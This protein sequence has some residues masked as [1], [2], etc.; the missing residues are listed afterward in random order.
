[1]PMP[2]SPLAR[3]GAFRSELH[4]SFTR[5]ADALFELGD[6]LLCSQPPVPSLPHLSLEPTHRR[7]WGSAYAA[8]ASGRIATERLRD[9]LVSQLPPAD[10]LVFAVDVTTW[11]RCDAE[12][13]PER[14]YYYHPSR[15]SAGQPIIAGWAYQWIAQ[16]SFDRD[17]WTAP[18]DA[19]RL[20]PLDDTDQQA[21]VQVRALLARLPAGGP[22]PWFVFD[23]GYD[24]AQ[25]TLDLAEAPV[26]VLVRL[27]SNRCFYADP[28]PRGPGSTGRP[29]RHGAKFN[30]A[31]PTT[32]SAPTTTHVVVDDQYGAVTVKAWTGLH[33]KQQRHLG[34][35]SRGPRPIVRGTIIRVQVDRVPARTRPPKVL[36]LWWS[37]PASSTWIWPGGP[38]SAG[39]TWSTPSGSPSR[40]SAGRPHGPA[41]PSRP[42]AGPGWCWPH[43]P[44]Y[45]WPARP[46]AISGCRGSGPDPNRDSRPIGC[47]AAF[48]S[49][50]LRSARRRP[51]R[52]PP[53]AP[54]AG[55]RAGP[56]GPRPATQRSRSPPRSQGASRPR[57]RRPPDRPSPSR[58]RRPR[59]PA[60]PARPRVKS[61][62]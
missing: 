25:L 43:T 55:P 14:G 21:A 10:P 23:G 16:L 49:F 45:A 30:L 32:W 56:R 28:P 54:Q 8:L 3:L 15:H 59:S 50:S 5:R 19:R 17:S 31:D 51:R 9:L 34:H 57:R 36:W 44:S 22:V 4:G 62:A 33:P 37:G 6:A 38:M 27:R 2:P 42:T 52:N 39:S 1:M 58:A 41:S 24:S 61:Q 53:V 29:R 46:P 60:S 12:C 18:V 40:P 13:S 47:A 26:A 48:R 7:G 20:Q 11:P 35:G